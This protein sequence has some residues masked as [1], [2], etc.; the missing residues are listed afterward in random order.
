VDA[1]RQAI[2]EPE[3]DADRERI[4]GGRFAGAW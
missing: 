1:G 3:P 2:A 4:T